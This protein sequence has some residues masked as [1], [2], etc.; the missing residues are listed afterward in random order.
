[1]T[2]QIIDVK[3]YDRLKLAN[4]YLRRADSKLEEAKKYLN[5]GYK[6]PLSISASQEVTEFSIKAVLILMLG[7]YPK[8]HE[9]ADEK[10]K[11]LMQETS[12]LMLEHYPLCPFNKRVFILPM[13][14]SKF[15]QTVKYGDDILGTSDSLFGRK[16]AELALSHAEE[17]LSN[18]NMMN[19][20]VLE[21][22][23]ISKDKIVWN[24][25]E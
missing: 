17:C 6:H 1:M 12:E 10:I 16:E 21:N 8:T 22:V 4:D 14:W 23:S 19:N 13:F 25:N 2:I 11:K 5:E 18:A 24:K 15:Y 7:R 3:N 20:T 9:F